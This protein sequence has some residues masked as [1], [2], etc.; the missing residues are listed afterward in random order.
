MYKCLRFSKVAGKIRATDST[1]HIFNMLRNWLMRVP[2]RLADPI[3]HN[4]MMTEL[5]SK[6][7]LVNE[8]DELEVRRENLILRQPV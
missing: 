4:R 3:N 5:P 8:L 7:T 6:A 1:P 2:Y